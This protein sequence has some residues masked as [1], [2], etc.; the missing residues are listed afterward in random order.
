MWSD[1]KYLVFQAP[2]FIL[3][4]VPALIEITAIGS[5]KIGS[6]I[7]NSRPLAFKKIRRVLNL[8][9]RKQDFLKAVK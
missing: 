4:H 1:Y 8:L 7:D 3:L 6:V 2:V 5:G 9:V